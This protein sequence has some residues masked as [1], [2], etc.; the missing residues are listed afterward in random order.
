[1]DKRYYVV[2]FRLPIA[3]T[4]AVSVEEAAR[5]AARTIVRD[6][7]IDISNWYAR[8]F[9]Y[10]GEH[11]TYGI[12]GEWFCNP[13]GSRFRKV[14]TNIRKHEELI[15]KGINPDESNDEGT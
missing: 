10:G 12:I 7:D 15:E 1:M 8:V 11:D 2:E 14:D 13:T 6:Y 3:V 4:D 5:K 9:E